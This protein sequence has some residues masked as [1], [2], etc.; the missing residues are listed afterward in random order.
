MLSHLLK[1]KD[2]YYDERLFLLKVVFFIP[3]ALGIISL[4]RYLI[5]MIL[6]RQKNKNKTNQKSK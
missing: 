3:I 6:K 4:I 5:I 1:N 2:L